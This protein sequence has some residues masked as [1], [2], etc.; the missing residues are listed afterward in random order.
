MDVLWRQ[1]LCEHG[2]GA[3]T[4]K[5]Q[6]DLGGFAGFGGG[7]GW[8]I[9]E[10]R[11]ENGI[12]MAQKN[13]I[14]KTLQSAHESGVDVGNSGGFGRF[15]LKS[16]HVQATSLCAHQRVLTFVTLPL[17]KNSQLSEQAWL[18][19]HKPASQS[20]SSSR[21]GSACSPK[22]IFHHKAML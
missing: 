7:F 2:S 1:S 16:M 11:S 22:S 12:V 19:S 4:H 5:A 14:V 6:V 20:A 18:M 13:F 8:V 17:P 9:C 3:S 21:A 15:P 10:M